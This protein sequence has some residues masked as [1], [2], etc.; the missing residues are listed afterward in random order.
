MGRAHKLTSSA[1]FRRTYAEGRRAATHTVIAHVRD[2]ADGAKPRL[3]LSAARGIRGAVERNR[4]KRRLRA[5]A[6]I[7]GP[8]LRSG[9]DVVLVGAETAGAAPFQN[10]V[11][12][13]R[14]AVNS[15]GGTQ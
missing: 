1:D 14:T 8:E 12:N 6:A 2:S 4:I 15:A 13:V 9:V 7:V 3:G 5:A 11:D 10:L